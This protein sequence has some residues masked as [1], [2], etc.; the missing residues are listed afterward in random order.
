[1]DDKEIDKI[2]KLVK[3]G[4]ITV[5]KDTLAFTKDYV[6]KQNKRTISGPNHEKGKNYLGTKLKLSDKVFFYCTKS[7][8]LVLRGGQVAAKNLQTVIGQKLE[9]KRIGETRRAVYN[10]IFNMLS[11][12]INNLKTKADARKAKNNSQ[13]NLPLN[14]NITE[15]NEIAQQETTLVIGNTRTTLPEETVIINDTQSISSVKHFRSNPT[16]LTKNDIIDI[17]DEDVIIKDAFEYYIP[18]K[19]NIDENIEA[20]TTAENEN[21]DAQ[22][23]TENEA[24]ADVMKQFAND[25]S[26]YFEEKEVEEATPTKSPMEIL[27]EQENAYVN[28]EKKIFYRDLFYKLPKNE[29]NQF[30]KKY[31]KTRN[32]HGK[33]S[34]FSFLK[35]TF[36]K[37]SVIDNLIDDIYES[38]GLRKDFYNECCSCKVLDT[39]ENEDEKFRN[40]KKKYY[41]E[42]TPTQKYK[43]RV[44]NFRINHKLKEPNI[45]MKGIFFLPRISSDV[46]IIYDIFEEKDNAYKFFS[47][48]L[49]E[50][51]QQKSEQPVK[52]KMSSPSIFRAKMAAEADTSNMQVDIG[53]WDYN[54]LS[55]QRKGHDTHKQDEEL[56]Q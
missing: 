52:H 29:Q 27:F 49:A 42:L 55:K 54:K 32:R 16:A 13:I 45:F 51:H 21:I 53:P 9:S 18:Q 11:F 34:T 2:I 10:S 26:E 30:L 20:Q 15:K 41:K 4:K 50:N 40:I 36:A 46:D 14:S 12:Y 17:P 39:Q 56:E 5:S 25:V 43:M 6:K 35:L 23:A 47:S 19:D 33:L 37:N 22:T 3:N 31:L 28:A 7:G 24:L 44:E 8:K 38:Y 1:M 48:L